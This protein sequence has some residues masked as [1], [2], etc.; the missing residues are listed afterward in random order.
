[1]RVLF[2]NPGRDLGGAERSLLLLLES[3]RPNG[4]DPTV[5]LFGDGPFAARLASLHIPTVF[6]YAADVV[7][8]ASRYRAQ[9][10]V[11]TALLS[12]QALPTVVRLARLA[13]QLDADVI[14]TRLISWAASRGAS[15]AAQ[16]CGTCA[17]FS[18]VDSPAASYGS[19]LGRYQLRCSQ[20][21]TR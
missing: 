21:Q 6:L 1:L 11:G 14:H 15:S 13:R 8:R 2:V 10:V 4:V 9:G 20:F 16:S 7:R 3:L 12:F 18:R 19:P 17:T 5:A